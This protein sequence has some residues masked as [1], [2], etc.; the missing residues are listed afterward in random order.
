MGKLIVAFV[1]ISDT[2]GVGSKYTHSEIVRSG[3]ILTECL[4]GDANL[5]YKRILERTRK[6]S[7]YNLPATTE[8]QEQLQKCLRQYI[9][10]S[11]QLKNVVLLDANLPTA[12][13]VKAIMGAM[14]DYRI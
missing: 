6:K 4:H 8:T 13:K 11:G 14:K 9:T 10:L 1:K 5:C 7:G 12:I 3:W 2:S